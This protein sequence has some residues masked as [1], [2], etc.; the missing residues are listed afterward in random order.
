MILIDFLP[1]IRTSNLYF[2]KFIQRSQIVLPVLNI[3]MIKGHCDATDI[4]WVQMTT[5]E[6][7]FYQ[8]VESPIVTCSRNIDI[9]PIVR[10]SSTRATQK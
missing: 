2:F 3:I 9:S 10:N 8:S 1:T 7:L 5:V 4:I 6:R